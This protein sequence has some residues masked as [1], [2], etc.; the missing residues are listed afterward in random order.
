M[1]DL[2]LD[3]ANHR[4]RQSLVAGAAD[5]ADRG[6][7]AGFGQALGAA[8]ADASGSPVGMMRERAAGEG[9][10]LAKGLARSTGSTIR[11][12][13]TRHAP[14]DGASSKDVDPEGDRHEAAPSRDRGGAAEPEHVR[15][16][17][18]EAAP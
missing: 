12:C 14:A 6:L 4:S 7:K 9:L 11:P 16:R 13:R 15:P 2:G 8:R 10:A 18:L 17:R 1:D 5:A 3:K